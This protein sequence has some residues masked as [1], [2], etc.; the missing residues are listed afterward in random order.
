MVCAENQDRQSKSSLPIVSPAAPT[1][2]GATKLLTP[3][4]GA[5]PKPF[6]EPI[7]RERHPKYVRLDRWRLNCCPEDRPSG[8]TQDAK[9]KQ[10]CTRVS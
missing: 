10:V 4:S 9:I 6:L 1:L 5:F 8:P 3:F 7:L 2:Q